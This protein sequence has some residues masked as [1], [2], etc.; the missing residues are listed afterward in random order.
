MAVGDRAK[1]LGARDQELGE[2][3]LVARQLVEELARGGKTRLEV[4]VARAR[5]GGVARVDLLLALDHLLDGV[6]G[7]RPERVEELVEVDDRGRV[8]ARERR[9]LRQRRRVVGPR[10]DRDVAIRDAGQRGR[11]DD[12]GRPVMERLVDRDR[13]LSLSV[14]GQ[15]DA[16]DGADR[17]ARD[18]HLV[19]GDE[20]A[21]VLEHQVVG[22]TRARAEQNHEHEHESDEECPAGR[23]PRD[24]GS[25]AHV[26][27]LV[28]R[29]HLCGAKCPLLLYLMLRAS[30]SS[31]REHPF[32]PGPEPPAPARTRSLLGASYFYSSP[33]KIDLSM[34]DL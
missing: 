31:R 14:V 2:R 28:L 7:G 11:A 6:P 21:T 30:G 23:R 10:R 34:Q 13:D 20:L 1:R 4:L 9:A 17:L 24:P 25:T 27:R 22:A 3:L 33:L 18:K 8:V 29:R 19:A 5:P 26:R 32:L 16:V 12:R 15:R